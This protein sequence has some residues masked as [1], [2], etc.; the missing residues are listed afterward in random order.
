ME[1]LG[2]FIGGLLL[3]ALLIFLITRIS[4]QKL[5]RDLNDIS[6]K[7]ISQASD[8]LLRQAA[9]ASERQNA[10]AAAQ[11]GNKKE[12]IDQALNE[13]RGKLE[14]VEH[15]LNDFNEKREVSFSTLSQQ[16][17]QANTQTEK[18]SDTTAKL[19]EVLSSPKSRGQWGE[20]M[21]DDVLR[22]CGLH[23]GINYYKNKT[24]ENVATRPDFTF[25]L[26][27]NL[28][29]NMDVKFPFNNFL[30]YQECQ[31]PALQESYKKNFLRDV[32]NRLKEV[33][34]REYINTAQ[35]TVDY[36]LIFI[37]SEQIYSFVN[38][39]DPQL[40]DDALKMK[41][42]VC[43]PQTLYAVL[44]IVRQAV[45]NFKM[46][47]RL[48]EILLVIDEFKNQWRKYCEKMETL[49]HRLDEARKDF[50]EIQGVRSRGLER[51]MS[52]IDNAKSEYFLT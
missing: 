47:E 3:G 31:D 19:K 41:I 20:R 32:R 45:D 18:L 5:R 9:A 2:S 46:S 22:L 17:R 30:S 37:P 27:Q 23:E 25:K 26:P 43:S 52:K 1:L 10:L 34:G 15:S 51:S 49:G 29:L 8:D 6:Q 14:R 4:H 40:I 35:N 33:T 42:I 38:Q 7:M 11:L 12:L 16:L 36:V 39:N 13:M 44:S 21:A 48:S 24:Q 28:F 50:D